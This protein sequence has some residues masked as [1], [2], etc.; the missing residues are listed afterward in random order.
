MQTKW[1]LRFQRVFKGLYPF[2]FNLFSALFVQRSFLLLVSHNL[3]GNCTA[4]LPGNRRNGG[5]S[6]S[7]AF[8]T[9]KDRE[10]IA[11]KT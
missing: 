1:I 11:F 7:M 2:L 10:K 6:A 5:L 3:L 4:S 8:R 9:K